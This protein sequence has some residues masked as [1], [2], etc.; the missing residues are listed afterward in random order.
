MS[1]LPTALQVAAPL[2]AALV[3][4]AV[5]ASAWAGRVPYPFDLEWMEGGMLAHAWRLDRG[6]PLYVAPNP[7]FVPYVYPPG[8]AAVVALL[9][10]IVGL[11]LPLGRLVSL[12]STIAAAGAI[13]YGARGAP[14]GLLLPFAAVFLG[15][16]PQAGAYYD[17]VR[18]DALAIALMAWAVVVGR[19]DRRGAPVVAGLLLAAAFLVKHNFALLGVPLALGIGAR[20]WRAGVI[21]AASA[22]GP[23]LA[24]VGLLQAWSDGGFLVWLLDVPA[25]HKM[26]WERAWVDTP[27]EW[28]T[29]LPGAWAGA[30]LAAVAA[31]AR[32]HR[33]PTW[34]T[35]T[36]PVWA[37]MAAAWW[38]T[39]EP[40]PD[41]ALR[42]TAYGLAYWALVAI[43]LALALD[44]F[45]ALLERPS[46]RIAWRTV[47]DVGVVGTA[48]WMALVMRV[49]DSGY[50]NVHAPLFWCLALFSADLV[51]RWWQDAP[52][53]RPLLSAGLTAQLLWSAAQIDVGRLVPTPADEAAGWELVAAMREVDGPI[54]SPFS[55]W[56]PTY[57]GRDPSLHAMGIWDCLYPDGP[58]FAELDVV[59]DALREHRWSLFLAGPHRLLG[60]P[61]RYYEEV[62]VAFPPGDPRMLP[63]TGFMARPTRLLTPREEWIP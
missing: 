52:A 41:L 48:G 42:P 46:W 22:A 57:A 36:V 60:D 23:A 6:L 31:A 37:G 29:A 9:G 19:E 3:L 10:K 59:E 54:L 44:A 63:Q 38:W 51:A 16:W 18:P 28:G 33:L 5:L 14:P 43:P 34:I 47:Y 12:G 50:V 62:R 35:A 55:A 13:A 32:R 15:T 20:D 49:H 30:G 53:L 17:I 24:A 8:Y 56:T 21:F 40:A 39:Y 27:R 45:G 58:Y 4:L 1:R 11:S 61:D 26:L 7:D 2:L 25:A